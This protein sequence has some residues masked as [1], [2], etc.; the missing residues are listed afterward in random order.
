MKRVYFSLFS[1]IDTMDVYADGE[2]LDTFVSAC[3][4]HTM[5]AAD[6]INQI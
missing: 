3:S 6:K 5:S 1:E 4:I 2:K